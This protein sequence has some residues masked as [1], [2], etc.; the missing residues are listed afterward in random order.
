MTDSVAC[1]IAKVE[2][3]TYFRSSS[4]TL[5]SQ[6]TPV[7]AKLARLHADVWHAFNDATGWATGRV[8]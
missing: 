3:G 2:S 4:S 1:G 6:S 8:G 7:A 5:R